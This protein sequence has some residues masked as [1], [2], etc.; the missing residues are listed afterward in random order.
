MRISKAKFD[1][2]A[3]DI[4][5]RTPLSSHLSLEHVI[6]LSF[7]RRTKKFG[8]VYLILQKWGSE[9]S[10]LTSSILEREEVVGEIKWTRKFPGF[11]I[12]YN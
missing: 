10:S 1:Q 12:V 11:G 7:E 3:S 6:V 4:D 5:I 9:R 2:M 8:L